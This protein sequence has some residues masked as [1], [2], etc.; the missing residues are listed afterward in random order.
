MNGTSFICAVVAFGVVTG[1]VSAS[2][3]P[4]PEYY[5]DALIDTT[6]AQQLALA[7]PTLSVNLPR[8][9]QAT[10]DVI[11]RLEED[12]FTMTAEQT[13]MEDATDALASRQDAFVTKYGLQNPSAD[14]VCAAGR[15]EIQEGT[16]MGSY[17]IEVSG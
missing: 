4:A 13:G 10:G 14:A 16:V 9:A 5:L 8:V 2:E 6:T 3:R 12:G 17:L 7:C 15:A 11:A 1:A